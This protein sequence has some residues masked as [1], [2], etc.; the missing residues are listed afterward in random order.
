MMSLHHQGNWAMQ[1]ANFAPIIFDPNV[2]SI[3]MN[4]QEKYS[5]AVEHWVAISSVVKVSDDDNQ[6]VWGIE[7]YERNDR[8]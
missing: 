6:P 1:G 5:A 8:G 4:D 7:K 2:R 3:V